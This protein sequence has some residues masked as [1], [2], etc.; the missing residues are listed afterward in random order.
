VAEA[1]PGVTQLGEHPRLLDVVG[2]CTNDDVR[3]L[4]VWPEPELRKGRPGLL[5]DRGDL[6]IVE[7]G[8]AH[9][10]RRVLA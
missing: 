4:G 2:Y 8:P 10:G 6:N 3:K 7:I 1:D 5:I 9:V